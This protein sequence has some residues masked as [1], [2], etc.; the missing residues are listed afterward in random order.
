MNRGRRSQRPLLVAGLFVAALVMGPRVLRA[1][2][3]LGQVTSG[4]MTSP[5]MSQPGQGVKLGESAVLHA[6][7][8]AEVGMDTNVFYGDAMSKKNDGSLG[9][10]SAPLARFSPQLQLTNLSRDGATPSGLLYT[11]GIA[12]TYRE[13][14]GGND[15]VKAQRAF[16][17]VFS[18]GV[19]HSSP[20]VGISLSDTFARIED[21]P[22]VESKGSITRDYNLAL[23]QFAF[24][25]GGGRIRWTIRYINTLDLYETPGLEKSDNMMHTVNV[26]TAW[27]WF[28]KTAIFLNLVGSRVQYLQTQAST[29]ARSGSYALG[30]STGLRGLVTP[31]LAL[32][33]GAGY[34]TAYYD[35]AVSGPA[36]FSNVSLHASIS[37]QLSLTSKLSLGFAHGFRNSAVIGTFVD[38]DGV[39]IGASQ[40][41]FQRVVFL[42]YGAFENRRYHD[43]VFPGDPMAP[44]FLRVDNVIG[45]GLVV[46]YYV[47]PWLFT[48]VGYGISSQTSNSK[49][50]VTLAAAQGTEYVKQLIFARIG[51]A[52]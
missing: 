19:S 33:V 25:P 12:T 17:P 48:G 10:T 3:L 20:R 44:A 31:K 43:V 27:H 7:A 46:D 26:D 39:Y 28:P 50:N 22:V 14:L 37:Y 24:A 35:G 47:K 1:Q 8:T 30:A 15:N 2:D 4:G 41:F 5:S 45:G 32:S 52:Y 40:T 34:S 16:N 23:L 9:K 36:G 29:S 13:Y 18:G 51:V 6:A 38:T 11:V 42:L 21:A 49:E